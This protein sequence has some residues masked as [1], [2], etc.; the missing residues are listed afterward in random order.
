MCVDQCLLMLM[1]VDGLRGLMDPGSSTS[2]GV[3]A[4]VCIPTSMGGHPLDLNSGESM[5]SL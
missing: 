4:T 2:A 5:K 1:L 3:L